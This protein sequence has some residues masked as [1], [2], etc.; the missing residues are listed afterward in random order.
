MTIKVGLIGCGGITAPHIKGYLRIPEQAKVTAVS[1]VVTENAEKRAA[2]VGGAEIFSD[3]NEM[4]AKADIDAVDICLPHHL[5][6]DAIVAA[7]RAKKHILCEKPLCL[8]VAE[9]EEVQKAVSENGVTLM[10]AHNQLTMPPVARV[11]Q[12]IQEGTF[13]KV[14]EIR[15]TDSFY[16]TFDPNSIG[17]RG[18]RAMIGGGELIDTGYHPTYLLLY[19]ASSEPVEVTAMLSKHRLEFMDGE[20][21]AQV[22]VRF[23]DGAVGNIVTS[24]AYEPTSTTE[25]F[26][27]VAE[28]GYAYSNGKELCYKVRGGEEQ[29]ISYEGVD[30]FSE[31]I[32]DFVTCLQEGRRPVNTEAEGINVL[33]V[34]LGAYKSVEEKRTVT[35]AD[36]V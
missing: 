9:A 4:L 29:K 16:H 23:A 5:H 26:S 10:C 25:K 28:K 12:L 7:A 1:D 8:T 6:K 36:L 2:E 32:K 27:L 31:E 19:L 15:T 20:D 3:Y 24:W 35:L 21:S 14:Y 34:I 11:K 33:K 18:N 17:W 22:L 13:G 30:T